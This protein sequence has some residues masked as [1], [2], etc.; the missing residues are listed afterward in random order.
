VD[1]KKIHVVENMLAK[2]TAKHKDLRNKDSHDLMQVPTHTVLTHS[3]S[4]FSLSS[5]TLVFFS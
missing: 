5:Q 3:L 2:V 4:S 1:S